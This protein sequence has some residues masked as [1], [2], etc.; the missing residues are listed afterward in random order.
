MTTIAGVVAA[1]GS[2]VMAADVRVVEPPTGRFWDSYKMPKVVIKGN[3]V[4]GVAGDK[5][6]MDH[7]I[8]RW[9]PTD[10]ELSGDAVSDM[11]N[12]IQPSLADHT[13]TVEGEWRALIGY[14]GM[15][16]DVS[17]MDATHDDE[18]RFAAVGSGA[19]YA[20]GSLASDFAANDYTLAI[21]AVNVAAMFDHN[22][23]GVPQVVTLPCP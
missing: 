16:F 18:R 5:H 6:L 1:D 7:I 23:G 8:H 12:I 13:E 11:V 22:T 21:R 14:G 17:P 4:I 20:L 2:I 3:I 19:A 15:L 10:L 9:N